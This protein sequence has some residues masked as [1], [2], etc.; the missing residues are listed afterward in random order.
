[1]NR[2]VKLVTIVIALALLNACAPPRPAEQAPENVVMP[3]EKRVKV[4]NT[5][6]SWTISG[7]MAAKNK[8]KGWTASLNWVQRG[9][10]NY[11]LRLMG[12]LGSGAVVIDKKGQTVSFRDGPKTYSSSN[13]EKLLLEH[14]GISLPVN[15]LYYWVRGLPAPGQSSTKKYDRYNH[16]TQLQQSGYTVSYER[17]TSVNGKDLPS[18]I[19]LTGHGLLIKLI[20]KSWKI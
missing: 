19:R 2:F 5:V 3:V 18:K 4:T 17:Y 14:T 10:N 12:P 20:I 11:Q 16:L 1:M 6:S 15:N 9:I 7:A 13:A 8:N